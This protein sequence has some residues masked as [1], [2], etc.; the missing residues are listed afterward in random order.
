MNEQTQ[1]KIDT[2]LT[3]IG[4]QHL[5]ESIS[6]HAALALKAGNDRDR[7]E[8]EMKRAEDLAG[9]IESIIGRLRVVNENQRCDEFDADFQRRYGP[10]NDR[11]RESA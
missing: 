11:Q 7:I 2:A 3:L 10:A 1:F 9:K 4:V 6:G 8:V 5:A